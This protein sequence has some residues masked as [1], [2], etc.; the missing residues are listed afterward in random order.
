MSGNGVAADGS[1]VVCAGPRKGG[2]P[3]PEDDCLQEL[4]WSY[5]RRVLKETQA[6]LSLHQHGSAHGAEEGG[7]EAGRLI[8]SNLALT[9]YLHNL[10]DTAT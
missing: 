8:S 3:G 4:R 1:T 10:T 7:I 6:D 9:T 2:R 5:D